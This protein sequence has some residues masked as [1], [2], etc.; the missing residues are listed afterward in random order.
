M[1]PRVEKKSSGE[2]E[3]KDL[4]KHLQDLV[5]Q[6]QRL[7]PDLSHEDALASSMGTP[8]LAELFK[9]VDLS[10]LEP[11]QRRRGRPRKNIYKPPTRVE[12]QELLRNRITQ[13]KDELED[14]GFG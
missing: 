6:F 1:S 10:K 11:K 7:N 5:E 12:R 3:N 4:A 13:L 2:S 14:E 8:Q 9:D